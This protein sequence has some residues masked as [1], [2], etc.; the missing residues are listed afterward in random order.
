MGG[1]QAGTGTGGAGSLVNMR[2]QQQDSAGIMPQRPTA[3]LILIVRFINFTPRLS[4]LIDA[5][6]MSH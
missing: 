3:F 2:H 1:N 4:A 5:L 6:T